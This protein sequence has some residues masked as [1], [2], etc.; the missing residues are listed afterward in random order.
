LGTI[1]QALDKELPDWTLLALWLA[2]IC[3]TTPLLD[4]SSETHQ[5]YIPVLPRETGCV[6]EW[7]RNEV[8]WLKGTQLYSLA[9]D[10]R[11]AAASSWLEVAPIVKQGES[12]AI[13]AKNIV[14][15]ESLTR[16][17]ALLLSRAV[18]LDNFGGN[19]VSIDS[20]CPWADFVNHDSSS[21]AFL[22]WD[23]S[24]DAV[25]LVSDRSY[26]PGEHVVSSYGQK[27]SGQILL[28]YGFVPEENPHDACLLLVSSDA[29]SIGKKQAELKL[30]AMERCGVQFEAVFP[31]HLD[32]MPKGLLERAAFWGENIESGEEAEELC[33][34]LLVDGSEALTPELRVVGLETVGAL[35]KAAMGK[36]AV[37]LDAGKEELAALQQAGEGSSRRAQVLNVLTHEH[38]VLNRTLFL[39]Q[40]ELREVRRKLAK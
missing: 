38:R 19:G 40:A 26:S 16:A 22:R 27:T 17:F 18:R 32:A 8:N 24:I 35:C 13:I 36:L 10:I 4:Y 28:S 25:V 7:T 37:G 20:L 14:T 29:C 30:A 15:E 6:L 3:N 34:H 21:S 33:V 12:T 1:I 31:L 23:P 39:V 9:N 2:E 5:S 11:S